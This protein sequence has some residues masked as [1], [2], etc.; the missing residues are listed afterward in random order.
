MGWDG[1]VLPTWRGCRVL[2]DGEFF[3]IGDTP[4]SFDSRYFGVVRADQIEGV[5]RPL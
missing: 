5:W 3:V 4:D 2:H 1:R